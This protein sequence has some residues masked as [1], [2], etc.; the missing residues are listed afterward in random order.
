MM[1]ATGKAMWANVS[2]PNTRFSPHK[3]MITLLTDEDTAMELEGA[4]LTQSRD[5]AGNPKYDQ[6]A[7]SFSKTATRKVKNNKT[8]ELEEVTNSP[9]KLIDA[10]G[11]PLDC[12]V[13]NGSDVTVK[14]RP[15]NSPYGTFA[16]LIAVKVNEL[17]EYGGVDSDNEEF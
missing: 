7:F 1:Y 15:Y 10:D 9:P 6:P 2:S 11:N 16:E 5:R 13:G 3:Y 4:G 14:I 8:N 12:L 17:I